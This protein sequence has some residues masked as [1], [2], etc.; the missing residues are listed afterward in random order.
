MGDYYDDMRCAAGCD[1]GPM[2]PSSGELRAARRDQ[3]ELEARRAEATLEN[4]QQL[5]KDLYNAG[6]QRN[7]RW[8]K[9]VLKALKEV[10]KDLPVPSFELPTEAV[11]KVGDKVY[12]PTRGSIS[13]G[14]DDVRG[15]VGV[16]MEI[17]E[18]I[19]AG[20]PAYFVRTHEQPGRSY[21]WEFLG[22][23]QEDLKRM[24]GDRWARPDPDLE[25]YEESW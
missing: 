24:Y 23:E 7:A 1:G 2:P 5:C 4:R 3:E 8:M 13:H 21:N 6:V 16:V 14:G 15:G 19:S 11:P 22:K 20:N 12:L 9:L 17:D 18:G 25:V 10:D